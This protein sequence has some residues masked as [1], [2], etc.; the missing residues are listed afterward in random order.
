MSRLFI[1][2]T[3]EDGRSFADRLCAELANHDPWLDRADLAGGADWVREIER[4]IDESDVFLPVLTRA[5]HG[6]R[7][8]P[9]ELARAFRMR[10]PLIPL[11]F[12]ADADLGLFLERTQYIDFSDPDAHAASLRTL[13]ER[14]QALP[15]GVAAADAPADAGTTQWEAVRARTERLARRVITPALY[16]PRLYVRREGAEEDLARFLSGS[17]PAL[18]VIGDS[19]VGKSSLLSHWALDLIAQGHAVLPYDCSTLADTE[20]EEELAR[21][22]GVDAAAFDELQREASQA[23]KNLVLIF[24]SIGDYRGSER[25][26]AQVL[27]RRVHALVTRLPGENI[28]V[29]VSCNTAAWER[30]QRSAP[31]RLDRRSFHY[32]GDDPYLR[33][34]NF[35]EQEGDEAYTRYRIAFDLH[36]SLAELPP[37]VRVRLREPVIL[38]MTAE[39]YRGA[40]QPLLAAN[41]GI[42]I[43]R[44]YFEERVTR[45]A[46]IVL[47]DE[48]AEEMLSRRTGALPMIDLARHERLGPQILDEDPAS[49]YSQLLDAGVL[50]EVRGDVRAGIVVKFSHS[51]VAAYA[52]AANLLKRTQTVG[53]AAAELVQQTA[54][55]P[56]GWEVARTLLLLSRDE[57]AF[58]SLA[59]S[60]DPE[61]RA[62]VSEA[63]VELHAHDA[64]AAATLLRKLLDAGSEGTRRTALKA[65]YNIGPAARDFFLRAAIDGEPSMRESVKNTLYLIW[66]NESHAGRQSVTETLYMIW[67][68]APGFTYDFLK[69]LLDEI[70]LRNVT[71][72]SAILEFI[73]DLTITIYIN[74]CDEQEV[75]ERTADLLHDL[76]VRRLRLHLFKTGILGVTIEKII[77]RSIARVFGKQV[78]DWLMFADDAPVQAFFRI[79]AERRALLTRIA[80]VYDPASS[81]AAAHDDILAMLRE[82]M[83]IFAG[84]AAMAIGVHAT[85]DFK[86][87]EPVIRKLWEES[88]AAERRWLLYAF[89][90]LMKDTPVEWIPFL[91]ELTRR[92]VEEHR[93]EFLH[94]TAV[95]AQHLDVLFI[96]LGLAYGKRGASSP[97]FEELL[98]KALAED[99]VP[100]VARLIAALNGVG[101]YFPGALFEI[102]RPAFAKLDDEAIAT[103]LVTTLATV[104]TLHFD[105][106]DQFLSV[107]DAPDRFR[108]RIDA[109]SDV[110][111]VHRFIRVLGYYN[112]GV[113]L[114]VHYPRMRRCFSAGSLRL[115]AVAQNP[116]QFVADYTLSAMRLLRGA[117]FQ[118]MEWTLPE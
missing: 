107:M 95:L 37:A 74:H 96:P 53:D 14:L 35:T 60:A 116:A 16:D 34:T 13:L 43:Y 71:K 100:L 65:A 45:P 88:G 4:A 39:A 77:F 110:A 93:D 112:N 115:L 55:F 8:A 83:P 102:L 6:A 118:V 72:L 28:R 89:L 36:S 113:H 17:E 40:K 3:R 21:D 81:L 94:P 82:E 84:A 54:Q 27:I 9:L 80:D 90:V 11:R 32:C 19:G 12:H 105:A 73:L 46:E 41:L 48:L 2:Y 22:L 108:H 7:F 1:S 79:P 42:G 44:R 15:E 31:I 69:S 49:P 91:E 5:Y 47:V 63:L 109:A 62:L 50:T 56:L 98:Q 67:R 76:S 51:R 10:K 18:V 33:L 38:R 103:A 25:N 85:H 92:Y 58:L 68:H 87:A 66:R 99:D 114:T 24:D 86:A 61:R 111:L 104:R 23:G 117:K 29:V 26:G 59:A 70:R 52:L 20:I 101:F 97:L 64:K 78:L 30:L 106:V 57:P 75:I